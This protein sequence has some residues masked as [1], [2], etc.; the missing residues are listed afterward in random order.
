MT[1]KKAS[2]QERKQQAERALKKVKA[3]SCAECGKTARKCH[4]EGGPH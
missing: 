4:C 2:K 3:S 1:D